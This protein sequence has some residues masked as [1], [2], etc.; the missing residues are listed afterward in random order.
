VRNNN[1]QRQTNKMDKYR[2][3]VLLYL[4]VVMMIIELVNM[5]CNGCS[6]ST[7]VGLEFCDFMNGEKTDSGFSSD[8]IQHNGVTTNITAS[9]YYDE[10]LKEM[11]NQMRNILQ[12]SQEQ[13]GSDICEPCMEK[14][15]KLM[16]ATTFPLNGYR[17]CLLKE[18]VE[19]L[20]I[21]E[22]AIP[23][24][25]GCPEDGL[26]SISK[27]GTF[28]G[29]NMPTSGIAGG[30]HFVKTA[31]EPQKIISKCSVYLP[32]ISYCQDTLSSCGC[33][34]KSQASGLCNK[35]FSESGERTIP[36]WTTSTCSN[37][38]GW[39][40]ND[41]SPR[42]LFEGIKSSKTNTLSQ[43]EKEDTGIVTGLL[44]CPN[45]AV[46]ISSPIPIWMPSFAHPSFIPKFQPEILANSM[47]SQG[48]KDGNIVKG[49][50]NP[51]AY[52]YD[53]TARVNNGS[54]KKDPIIVLL[55]IKKNMPWLIVI[56]VV[57]ITIPV[58]ILLTATI[59]TWS[60]ICVHCIRKIKKKRAA[61]K[62]L[63]E[64]CLTP[65]LEEEEEIKPDYR[66][67]YA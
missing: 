38:P 14:L 58:L 21:I 29:L 11:F 47:V 28:C 55:W 5:Q 35:Y 6:E 22:K 42:R 24:S 49:C 52:K 53:P 43:S 66:H 34:T 10:Y 65:V 57:L 50:I 62:T 3:S 40:T 30:F 23:G 19:Q 16:C 2:W 39:C 54:C 48:P 25:C 61:A 13:Y 33:I 20:K 12:A 51:N 60:L 46:C 41:V 32:S 31:P 36:S 63:P 37:T 44:A 17:S 26:C 7:L 4:L 8:I 15:K 45:S 67:S 59:I 9:R 56:L 27:N 1:N 64:M 18:T